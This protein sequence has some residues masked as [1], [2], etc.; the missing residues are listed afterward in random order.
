M[1]PLPQNA[2]THRQPLNNYKH[3]SGCKDYAMGKR[4]C[5]KATI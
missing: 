3:R 1:L 2:T 4:C 5:R